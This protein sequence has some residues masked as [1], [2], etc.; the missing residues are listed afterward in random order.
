MYSVSWMTYW[1]TECV[2]F[3]IQGPDFWS[4]LSG[5][6]HRLDL[7]EFRCYKAVGYEMEKDGEKQ[8][9]VLTWYSFFLLLHP[10][11]TPPLY[12]AWLATWHL[13]PNDI[14][15]LSGQQTCGHGCVSVK[16]HCQKQPWFAVFADP[17]CRWYYE[18]IMKEPTNKSVW[19][20]DSPPP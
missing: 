12:W 15:S 4:N 16:L 17:C 6:I 1:I 10:P 11:H 18:A 13:F 7:A 2:C 8:W 14:Q 5:Q 20:N 19:K 3:L 9:Q